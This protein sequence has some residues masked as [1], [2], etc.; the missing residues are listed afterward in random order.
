[1]AVAIGRRAA[2][3]LLLAYAIVQ[4]QVDGARKR[5]G[6]QCLAVDK[7]IQ[8]DDS[9]I[10]SAVL[11]DDLERPVLVALTLQETIDELLFVF[12]G[13][14]LFRQHYLLELCPSVG[15]AHCFATVWNCHSHLTLP[16][17]LV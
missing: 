4:G 11:E 7:L 13:E 15:E 3:I 10:R 12:S 16:Y 1:M 5:T 2:Q 9:V 6:R 8:H 17:L 14:S